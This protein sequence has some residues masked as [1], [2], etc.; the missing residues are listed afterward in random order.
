MTAWLDMI[1]SA[2]YEA[3]N[4]VEVFVRDDDAGLADD[5]LLRLLNLFAD[6]G[7]AIDL[8][9]IPTAISSAM[10][11]K[12]RQMHSRG[13][14]LGLHQH[15]CA[16]LNHETNGRKCEFGPSRDAAHQHADICSGRARLAG[17]LG[18]S[19]DPIFTPPW[20]RCT[21][22]TV[23][24]LE[25]EHFQILSRDITAAPLGMGQL[26][27]LPVTVDWQRRRKG[28]RVPREIIAGMFAEQI[29]AGD[30]PIGLMLHHETMDSEDWDDL[31]SLAAFLA[32]SRSFHSRRMIETVDAKQL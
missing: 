18:S 11:A 22:D 1:R 13:A 29:R 23:K 27:H 14:R 21:D 28:A 7:L 16:H 3:A 9:V 26:R 8:A 15:G 24:A 19:L 30:R 4:P 5:A 32:L 20:N 2:A 25:A 10:A 17:L 31:A 12:L 6:H